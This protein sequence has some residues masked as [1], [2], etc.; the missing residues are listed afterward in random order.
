MKR[1][2]SILLAVLMV[3]G[4]MSTVALAEDT[5]KFV[6]TMELSANDV[7][8]A[9]TKVRFDVEAADDAVVT[10]YNNG[11][12]VTPTIVEADDAETEGLKQTVALTVNNGVNVFTAKVGDTVSAA[13]TFKASTYAATTNY[14]DEAGLVALGSGELVDF[15]GRTNVYE[16][17][18]G[19]RITPAGITS[20]RADKYE[21]SFDIYV[22]A[23]P[24]NYAT[25][26]GFY[27]KDSD[28]TQL[29]HNQILSIHKDG[30]VTINNTVSK[31]Y[32]EIYVPVQTWQT[33]KYFINTADATLD[34]YIDGI[35]V[36]ADVHLA[37]DGK[38][39]AS[40]VCFW[41][42]EST[43]WYLDNFEVN[44]ISTPSITL[45]TPAGNVT[46]G[47][48][49][50]VT[51]VAVTSGQSVVKYIDG[52]AS[53]LGTNDGTYEIEIPAGYST[54]SAAI[55]NA[56]GTVAKNFETGADVKT[57]D[58]VFA[59]LSLVG[60]DT[61]TVYTNDDGSGT[62]EAAK[63]FV[64]PAE[65]T[66]KDNWPDAY[67][68]DY[69]EVWK[70]NINRVDEGGNPAG[71]YK[72]YIK[73]S[74]MVIG[75]LGK[76][77][78]DG[79]GYLDYDTSKS[80]TMNSSASYAGQNI[81]GDALKAVGIY[82]MDFDFRVDGYD[83][84]ADAQGAFLTLYATANGSRK[85][86]NLIKLNKTNGITTYMNAGAVTK[87]H[88][89]DVTKWHNVKV[90][91]DPNGNRVWIYVDGVLIDSGVLNAAGN[92]TKVEKYSISAPRVNSKTKEL[93]LY[94]DNIYSA[95]HT[96]NYET[97]VAAPAALS[98]QVNANNA[99]V[100]IYKDAFVT[101]NPELETAAIIAIDANGAAEVKTYK[102]SD[103]AA[104]KTFGFN[105][106]GIKKVFVW[107]WSTLKPLTTP[108]TK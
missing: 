64:I 99:N 56:D 9:G 32:D 100:A 61:V 17:T 55:V 42:N 27:A 12:A 45:N 79:D 77:D 63:S 38:S 67:W 84:G 105:K 11:V 75:T 69:Y 97:T 93:S 51:A 50:T 29:S 58:A 76:T 57:A 2:L 90:E 25:P 82:E 68:E 16:R 86:H 107:D 72:Y 21:V 35:L 3:M 89:I 31:V 30:K 6:P 22:N 4:T 65:P 70:N 39:F 52:I 59:A 8:K 46:E 10:Y 103:T 37:E 7:L 91:V 26:V 54:V 18:G 66:R 5:I 33:H 108:F 15:G 96:A 60:E 83:Q 106:A 13:T 81:E 23:Y 98:G 20:I 49:A 92:I 73:G 104:Y 36:A 19:G 1:F 48:K 43:D 24:G 74:V 62:V 71:A 85:G 34:Y 14:V 78:E 44:A 53:T 47:S 87:S 101:A 40:W 102:V 41:M 28:G 88:D 80:Y 95:T 94:V